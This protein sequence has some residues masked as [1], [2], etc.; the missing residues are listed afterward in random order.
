MTPAQHG[1]RRHH[2]GVDARAVEGKPGRGVARR[3]VRPAAR[4]QA[5]AGGEPDDGGCAE[6]ERVRDRHG[7][8]RA[9]HVQGMER[10]SVGI[11][12]DVGVSAKVAQEPNA[13]R[14][15]RVYD[16]ALLVGVA[17]QERQARP[18]RV[19][20]S[21][22]GGPTA[23]GRRAARRLHEPDLGTE[24]SPHRARVFR[25]RMRQFD[26]AQVLQQSRHRS[27]LSECQPQR[28]YTRRTGTVSVGTIPRA[29][30]RQRSAAITTPAVDAR[31]S[32]AP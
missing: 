28:R 8:G 18:R 14:L 13:R 21:R 32:A 30:I 26:D 23:P 7:R 1:H 9:A 10:R 11:E 17:G 27:I 19:A 16:D 12:H 15:A 29:L 31:R 6:A 3:L 22:Y 20:A 4:R 25:E 5:A 24:T 2:R